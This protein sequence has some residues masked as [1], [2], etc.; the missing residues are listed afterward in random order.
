VITRAIGVSPE[1]QCDVVSGELRVGDAFVL[2]SDGLTEHNADEDIARAMAVGRTAQE[3]CDT[4]IA[5]TLE[6]GAKD[7]V[8]VMVLRVHQAGLVT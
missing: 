8:T 2:C 1:P 3:V 6:R 4:L 7:N 5:Q